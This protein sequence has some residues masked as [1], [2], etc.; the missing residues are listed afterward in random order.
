MATKT[1]GMNLTFLLRVAAQKKNIE[2][3]TRGYDDEPGAKKVTFLTAFLEE[4]KFTIGLFSS[5]SLFTF[6]SA[7]LP[8]TVATPDDFRG[9]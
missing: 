3:R 9:E 8:I 7:S 4:L 2:R 6:E 1:R 5:L